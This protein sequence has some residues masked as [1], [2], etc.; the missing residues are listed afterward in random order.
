M[1]G[2]AQDHAVGPVGLVLVVLDRLISGQSI[3]V[4]EQG[5]LRLFDDLA[6]IFDDDLRD[7]LFLD[8]DRRR[9]H[10]QVFAV[11]LILAAPDELRVEV[12]VAR[13]PELGRLCHVG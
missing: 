2:V 10:H 1:E 7:D 12:G 3:E 13:V 11:L 8:V 5:Q 6:K 9:I 4:F